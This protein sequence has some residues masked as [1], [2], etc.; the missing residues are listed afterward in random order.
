MSAQASEQEETLGLSAPERLHERHD[1]SGF[2]CNEQSINEYLQKAKKQANHKNA[3]VYVVCEAD[4]EVVKGFYTLSNGSVLRDEM[5]SKMAR[6]S[7]TEIPV[8][9]LGRIGV[10]TAFQGKGVGLDLLQ[11]A[12]ERALAASETVGS[13]AILIHALTQDLAEYYMKYA[14][15]VQSPISPKTLLLSLR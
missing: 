11:D 14:G 5:P 6:F 7:P 1:L 2:D 8:T 12:I 4:T 13:R 3:V 15:F 9:V 10:D